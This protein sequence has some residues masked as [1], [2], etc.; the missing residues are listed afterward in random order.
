MRVVER[1]AGRY[2]MEEVGDFGRVYRWHP[3]SVLVECECGRRT[4]LKRSDVID[5]RPCC[6]CGAVP[7]GAIREELVLEVLDESREA[8]RRPW[9]YWRTSERTGL[10]I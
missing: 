8:D 7:T 2:D 4:A 9:R 3:E 5:S 1:V 6:E 10:P